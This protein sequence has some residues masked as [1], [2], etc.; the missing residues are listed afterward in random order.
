[1]NLCKFVA[2]SYCSVHASVQTWV[3]KHDLRGYTSD[4]LVNDGDAICLKFVASPVRGGGY[5]CD[6][7]CDFVAKKINSLNFS[8]LFFSVIFSAVAS[9]V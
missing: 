9:P 1:M 7:V 8:R 4:F 6:K 5:T 3:F 2:T